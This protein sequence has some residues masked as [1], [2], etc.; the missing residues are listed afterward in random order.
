LSFSWNIGD[1]AD[2]VPLDWICG[3]PEDAMDLGLDIRVVR[4]PGVATSG[5]LMLRRLL[6][7]RRL[8]PLKL[9]LLNYGSQLGR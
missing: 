2:R 3:P 7:L 8:L 9:T 5:R 4:F 6:R 1:V